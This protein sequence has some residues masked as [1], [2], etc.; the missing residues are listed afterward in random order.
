MYRVELS[1]ELF[2]QGFSVCNIGMRSTI[3]TPLKP[4]F[5]FVKKRI[6]NPDYDLCYIDIYNINLIVFP[7]YPQMHQDDC[8]LIHFPHQKTWANFSM[9]SMTTIP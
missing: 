9:G 8:L 6:T 7:D 2:F 4:I 1:L 5:G 3:S